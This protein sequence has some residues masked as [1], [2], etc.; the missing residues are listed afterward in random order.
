[1]QIWLGKKEET[2]YEWAAKGFLVL[3]PFSR[4][5][6]HLSVSCYNIPLIKFKV[7]LEILT[8]EVKKKQ[9][10]TPQL[11]SEWEWHQWSNNKKREDYILCTQSTGSCLW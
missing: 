8:T 6:S 10:F 5:F 1:M 7:T 3:G 9:K 4:R 2:K 11:V